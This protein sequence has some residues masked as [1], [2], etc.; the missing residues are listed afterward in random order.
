MR[1]LNSY[2]KQ[3]FVIFIYIVMA[4]S[5]T[6]LNNASDLMIQY[7]LYHVNFMVARQCFIVPYAYSDMYM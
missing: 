5:T 2:I 7:W 3:K 6:N 4:T 1:V